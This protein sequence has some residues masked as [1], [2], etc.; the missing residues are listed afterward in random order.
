VSTPETDEE[1]LARIEGMVAEAK[2]AAFNAHMNIALAD[3]RRLY[4]LVY[5]GAP[6]MDSFLGRMGCDFAL[7]EV[8]CARSRIVRAVAARVRS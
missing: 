8:E 6:S 4:M 7:Y 5:G 3:R 2:K 1:F